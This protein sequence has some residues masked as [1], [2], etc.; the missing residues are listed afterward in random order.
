MENNNTAIAETFYTAMG[1]KNVEAMEK[2][3]H[4]EIQF[5]TPLVAIKGKEDYL[6]AVANFTAFF[7]TLTIRAKFGEGDQAMV[8]YDLDYPAPIGKLP[9]AALMT[10]QK[11]L[12]V[13][14][15]LFYD[16][17]PFEKKKSEILS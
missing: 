12:I 5:S 6:E 16:A 7:K 15:E 13:K 3:I 1:E 14:I 2:Y 17:R 11:E 10:F 9:A 8:V 4:P